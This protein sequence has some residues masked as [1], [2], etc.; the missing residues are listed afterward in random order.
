[1]ARGNDLAPVAGS[2]DTAAGEAQPSP[3][4]ADEAKARRYAALQVVRRH[5][6][7]AWDQGAR[8]G[9]ALADARI[10]LVA[11][12]LWADA[13]SEEQLDAARRAFACA[14]EADSRFGLA[15]MAVHMLCSWARLAAR[16]IC[17]A[18]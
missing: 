2:I 10:G 3:A 11:L 7:I 1:M 6:H 17:E 12:K 4:A 14:C 13:G 5:C 15:R 16:T 9:E 8:E 18:R